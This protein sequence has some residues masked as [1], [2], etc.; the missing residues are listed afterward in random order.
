LASFHDAAGAGRRTRAAA[1]RTRAFT[2]LEL[3]VV[4]SVIAILAGLLL[5]ALAKAKAKSQ[6]SL[7]LSNYR[8]LALAL[9][10][11]ADDH[12]DALPYNM[13][14]E[15]I[16]RSIAE[17]R[18][19]NWV[20]NVMT[21]E[22]DPDNTNTHWLVEGGL[23]PYCL[24]VGSVFKC[25]SD[26]ALSTI[27][28]RAGW[29]SRVRSVS[30]NAMFGYAAGFLQGG[31][32]TNNPYHSQFFKLAE[33]REPARIFSFVDEHPDSINDGY[34]LNRLANLEWIDLPASYHNGAATL[35]FAD[36]HA[37]THRW[38]YAHTKPPARPD[39]AALPFA[40][41]PTERAD[42]DWLTTRMTTARPQ[43]ARE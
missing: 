14:A 29:T 9:Q 34:F 16:R 38:L 28:R 6:G 8:Q 19:L 7:C 20:N 30:L 3:L 36:G 39:A 21:W 22:L 11:Y 33:V 40:V 18:Y 15:G 25:P 31:V 12:D 10:L 27:Q 37:E 26:T 24:R 41:P 4:A 35:A 32:N 1:A 2:L 42:Y 13:G 43:A 5:P 17:E 23:G